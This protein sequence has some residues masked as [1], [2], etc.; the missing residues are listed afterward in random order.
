ML[1]EIAGRAA[2]DY[3]VGGVTK[4][5]ILT[6]YREQSIFLA[7]CIDRYGPQAPVAHC[8]RAAPARESQN[9]LF[10]NVYGWFER[11]DRGLY[12]LRAGAYDEIAATYP[13]VAAF[14]TFRKLD[15]AGH[16]ADPRRIL[17]MWNSDGAPV[18]D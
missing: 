6:A 12:G 15:E 2:G 4:R 7:C 16:N 13:G 18:S 3:N 1:R 8:A 5:A 14:Y 9:I 10:R 17:R 11:L